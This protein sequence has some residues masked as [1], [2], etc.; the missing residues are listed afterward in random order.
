M[1]SDYWF[2]DR[3]RVL[4]VIGVLSALVTFLLGFTS[5]STPAWVFY[6]LALVFGISGMGWNAV[7]LT[8]VGEVSSRKAEGL[9]IGVAFFIGTLG[10]MLGPPFFGLL[11]DLSTHYFWTWSFL[12]LWMLIVSGV[13][14]W[15]RKRMPRP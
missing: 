2:G 10:I 14:F 6:V 13:M 5:S 3:R 4:V 8:L 9:G 12:S 1:T 7:W 11:V 15:A